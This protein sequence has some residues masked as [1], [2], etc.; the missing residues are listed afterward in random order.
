MI[1]TKFENMA[2][3]ILEYLH[4]T[5]KIPIILLGNNYY[6]RK[7]NPTDYSLGYLR[8]ETKKMH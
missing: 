2:I 6:V 3:F 8:P 5:E 7:K 4:L 1:E